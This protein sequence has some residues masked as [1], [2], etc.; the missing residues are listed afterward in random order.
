MVRLV[1]VPGLRAFGRTSIDSSKPPKGTVMSKESAPAR[2]RELLEEGPPVSQRRPKG[3][4]STRREGLTAE[5]RAELALR[6][7]AKEQRRRPPSI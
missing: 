7:A 4:K 3:P 2:P 5:R 6:I 1:A